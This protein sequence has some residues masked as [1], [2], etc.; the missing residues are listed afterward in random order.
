MTKNE[1]T[2]TDLPYI[3]PWF[4]HPTI[5][6]T[7]VKEH[8]PNSEDF[9]RVFDPALGPSTPQKTQYHPDTH[10]DPPLPSSEK[11]TFTIMPFAPLSHQSPQIQMKNSSSS[12][13]L[14]Q[15]TTSYRTIFKYMV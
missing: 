10:N 7:Q 13:P 15:P 12:G 3:L 14:S 5:I 8:Y 9:L 6:V 11:V 2:Q 1:Q 4:S